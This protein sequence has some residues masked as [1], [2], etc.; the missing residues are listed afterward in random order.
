MIGLHD[1][2]TGAALGSITEEQLQFLIDQL[3]EESSEDQ[4]YYINRDTLDAF[5]EKNADPGLLDILERALGDR[6]DIE[7]TWSRG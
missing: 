3:E 1:K 2:D 5:R 4:D 6:A 7:I